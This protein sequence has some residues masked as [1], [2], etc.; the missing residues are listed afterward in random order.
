MRSDVKTC[1]PS[2][3]STPGKA[4]AGNGRSF[5][6]VPGGP[7][8]DS[9][10]VNVFVNRE[11]APLVIP[12]GAPFTPRVPFE[13]LTIIGTPSRSWVVQV[14]DDG[15]MVGAPATATRK[16]LVNQLS[17]TVLTN[18]APSGTPSSALLSHPFIIPAQWCGGILRITVRDVAN[19][20][21]LRKWILPY[22]GATW[23]PAGSLGPTDTANDTTIELSITAPCAGL[24]LQVN[25]A[26]GNCTVDVDVEVPL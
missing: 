13:A 12:D 15:E 14:F 2:N 24:Y 3:A 26:F 1:D 16:Q 8:P 25:D 11:Q 6:L 5:R 9:Y 19:A 17:S 20:R 22:T 21:S 7:N 23:Y 10:P 18:A 4:E